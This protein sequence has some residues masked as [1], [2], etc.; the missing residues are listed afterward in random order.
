MKRSILFGCNGYIGRH[1]SHFLE[2]SNIINLNYDIHEKAVNGINNYNIIDI[3]KREEFDKINSDIDYI[4]MFAGLT[5]TNTGFIDYEKFYKVNE[6]GLLNLTTWMHDSDCC[7]KIIYPSTRLIYKGVCGRKIKESD[8]KEAKTIYALNKINAEA[9]LWMYH[10]YIGINYTIFRICVPYGNLFDQ[11]YSYGTL[12]F[13]IE[14]ARNNEDITLYGDGE[15]KRTFT[16]VEDVCKIMISTINCENTNNK[17][18]NIGGENLSLKQVANMVAK[19]YN[20]NITYSDWPGISSKLETGDTV[21]DD[22]KIKSIT[23]YQYLHKIV[24]EL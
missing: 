22:T 23:G 10:N 11:N 19:K 4:F 18:Y 3:T 16:H 17:I 2:L 14:K 7:A 13:F 15:L 6:L 20:V 9:I 8:L 24:N 5:G 12:G 1:L 21:F